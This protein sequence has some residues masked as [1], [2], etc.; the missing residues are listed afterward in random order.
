[1]EF[2]HTVKTK[3]NRLKFKSETLIIIWIQ[4]EKKNHLNS[5]KKGALKKYQHFLW[6]FK[7]PKSYPNTKNL[8]EDTED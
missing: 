2:C 8:F 1:M 3:R 5:I 6:K 7:R 4:V